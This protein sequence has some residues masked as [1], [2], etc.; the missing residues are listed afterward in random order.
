MIIIIVMLLNIDGNKMVIHS[1]LFKYFE[2]FIW[3]GP[4]TMVTVRNVTME[5]L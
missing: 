1:V 2:V 5:M 4:T 3:L